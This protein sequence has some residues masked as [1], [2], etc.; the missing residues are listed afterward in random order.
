MHVRV[1]LSRYRAYSA[2]PDCKGKR[3]Q[4]D[5]LLYQVSV[6]EGDAGGEGQGNRR[7]SLAD[8][9]ALSVQE[10]LRMVDLLAARLNLKGN[11][12][13]ELAFHEVRARLGFL[14]KWVW[15]ISRSTGPRARC[16]GRNGTGQPHDVSRHA[17]GEYVVCPG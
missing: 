12:P 4:P 7:M 14:A 8:F 1:L 9:Y 10:S 2:C 13:L 6:P 5:A 17:A 15:V 3:L 16:P 11:R